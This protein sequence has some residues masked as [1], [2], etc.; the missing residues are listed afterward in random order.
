M[1]NMEQL[2]R[3]LNT[4]LEDVRIKSEQVKQKQEEV[5]EMKKLLKSKYS[6]VG[7]ALKGIEAKNPIVQFFTF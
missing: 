4:E 1:G 5:D 7:K 3:E 2:L 6:H